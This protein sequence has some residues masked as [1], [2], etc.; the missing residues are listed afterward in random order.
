M[1]RETAIMKFREETA[2]K[3]QGYRFQMGQHLLERAEQLEAMVKQG[4]DELG[5][6]MELQQKE[7]VSFLY[8]SLLKSDLSNRNYQFLL[9]AMNHQWYLDEESLE[10]Y[11]SAGDLFEPLD[12]IWDYLTEE[13]RPYMGVINLYD[14]RSMIFDELKFIDSGISQILRYR[15][16][17]WE[18]KGIFAGVTLAPYWLLKW[19]EYRDQ[20]E[21]IIQT[22]RVVKEKHIW[23]EE[24]RK[25]VHKPETLVFSFWY[26]GK[27]EESRLDKLDMKFIVFEESRLHNLLF[28]ECNLEGSRFTNNQLSGCRFENCNLWGADFSGCTFEQVSFTGSELT[29]AVFPAEGV[30]FLNLEPEQ[31]QVVLL[32]REES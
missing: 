4:M 17:D 30:P 11:V 32:K 29:G 18:K 1:E 24:I 12:G 16:R 13:S 25:A 5:K 8:F 26:Q 6:K 3:I 15:L 9:H 23:R 20:T 28:T 7:Y 31:L 22:D 27:Y 19:G 10:V 2:G 21:F 14:I